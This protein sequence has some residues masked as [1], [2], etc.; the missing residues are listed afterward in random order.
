MTPY[1]VQIQDWKW[2]LVHLRQRNVS[3]NGQHV[4][5]ATAD[6]RVKR[7][8]PEDEHCYNNLFYESAIVSYWWKLYVRTAQLVDGQQEVPCCKRDAIRW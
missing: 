3:R 8:D 1:V 4:T 5:S 6:A 2:K 7:T